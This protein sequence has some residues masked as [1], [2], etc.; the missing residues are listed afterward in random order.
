MPEAILCPNKC[1]KLRLVNN[2]PVIADGKYE[3]EA[4]ALVIVT[5]TR[6]AGEV[7]CCAQCSVCGFTKNWTAKVNSHGEMTAIFVK[8]E[9]V[10][11]LEFTA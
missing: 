5:T 8:G 7:D 10:D 11:Q 3:L 6:L 4:A 1:Q 2:R 9:R